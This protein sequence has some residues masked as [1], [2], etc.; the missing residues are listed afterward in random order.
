MIGLFFQLVTSLID[1]QK[2]EFRLL[3]G[4]MK[5]NDKDPFYIVAKFRRETGEGA[6]NLLLGGLYSF[7]P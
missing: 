1:G 6:V 5:I 7:I 3:N 4:Q 2:S